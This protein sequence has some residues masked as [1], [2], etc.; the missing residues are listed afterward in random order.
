MIQP[1]PVPSLRINETM[2]T[3]IIELMKGL[4][5]GE[6]LERASQEADVQLSSGAKLMLLIPAAEAV[7]TQAGNLKYDQ[8][9]IIRSMPEH[10]L[11]FQESI[12]DFQESIRDLVATMAE[13]ADARDRDLQSSLLTHD[14]RIQVRTSL[15]AIRAF[16]RQFCNIP[17]FC[18]QRG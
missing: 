2:L 13:S 3:L 16:S 17:P 14:Q 6:E 7:L 4:G 12:R 1:A 10:H 5:L 18:D 15:S 11:Q 8:L 9:G